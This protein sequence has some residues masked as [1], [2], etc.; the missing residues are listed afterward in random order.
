M[1]GI[2]SFI[3]LFGWVR[4]CVGGC[5]RGCVSV[6]GRVGGWVRGWVRVWEWSHLTWSVRI[7]VGFSRQILV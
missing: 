1:A 5:V 6:G 4:E 7:P 2:A 3:C